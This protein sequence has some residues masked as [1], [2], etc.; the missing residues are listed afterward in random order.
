MP[1]PWQVYLRERLNALADRMQNHAGQ[2]F[3]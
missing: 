3:G 1:E 2:R